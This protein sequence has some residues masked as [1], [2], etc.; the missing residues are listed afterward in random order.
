MIRSAS[1]N[2]TVP[3]SGLMSAGS[4][5]VPAGVSGCSMLAAMA[6]AR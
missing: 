2:A 5:N 3:T 6:R 1:S 4:K